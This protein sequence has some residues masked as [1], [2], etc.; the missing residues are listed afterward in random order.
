MFLIHILTLKH[1]WFAL[2]SSIRPNC[3]PLLCVI[4]SVVASPFLCPFSIQPLFILKRA[5][6]VLLE[7]PLPPSTLISAAVLSHLH[8]VGGFSP[9]CPALERDRAST[10]HQFSAP[11]VPMPPPSTS[12][13]WL[14]SSFMTSA[15]TGCFFSMVPPPLKVQKS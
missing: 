8:M 7:P 15:C 9:I 5:P 13:I 14:V 1:L 3:L 4:Q 11:A 10:P 6:P 12:T 2:K